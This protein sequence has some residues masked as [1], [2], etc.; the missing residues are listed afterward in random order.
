METRLVSG[1][2]VAPQ[3]PAAPPP[4]ASSPSLFCAI[5]FVPHRCCGKIEPRKQKKPRVSTATRRWDRS[6]S[7]GD[8]D[9]EGNCRLSP[10]CT[11][12]GEE[13]THGW[14]TIQTG[15]EDDGRRGSARKESVR[16]ESRGGK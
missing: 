13:A 11:A 9:A 14:K 6:I 8:V 7:D 10:R 1:V 2:T 16:K 12:T 4:S 5:Y 15:R 3:V